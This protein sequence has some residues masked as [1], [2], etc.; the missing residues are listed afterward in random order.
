MPGRIDENAVTLV[1]SASAQFEYLGFADGEIV[2]HDIEMNL[3]RVG[4]IWPA[5]RHEIGREL[6]S[7]SRRGVVARDHDPV[8]RLEDD[9]QANKGRV[10]T[11]QPGG[12]RTVDDDVVVA[13][14]H[15]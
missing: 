14:N 9:W 6:E 7:E 5:G 1:R 8:V 2:D 13:S 4:G 3:L 12:I 10:E 11:S 15:L